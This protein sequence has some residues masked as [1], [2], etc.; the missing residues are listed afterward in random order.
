MGSSM[1]EFFAEILGRKDG[2]CGG[3]GGSMHLQDPKNGF[4]GSVPIVAATVPLAVGAAISLKMD[5][6]SQIS[7]AYLGDGA[8]EEGIVHES[9][10]LSSILNLPVVYVIENNLF[11][12]H[13]HIDTRQT[14][15]ACSRFAQA[16][17]I[18]YRLVDGN[19]V[20]AVRLAMKELSQAAKK[21]KKPGLI[22]AVTYR[23]LGH[24]DWREDIDVGVN[25]SKSE[26]E[27]WKKSDPIQR[28][29]CS[30]L[31]KKYINENFLNSETNLL[32][33]EIE[34]AWNKALKSPY[35]KIIPSALL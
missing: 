23:W 22:E 33:K 32:N 31:E 2:L 12:S 5:N 7:V 11:A 21:D 26:I 15:S 24:V 16:N 10:N 14:Q 4:I 34:I 28:L 6:K 25:R 9:F 8:I 20:V 3:M 19:D 17:G 30:M 29:L 13:M 27:L 1:Y 18:D 35:P